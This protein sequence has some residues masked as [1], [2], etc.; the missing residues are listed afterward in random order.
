MKL[1][2]LVSSVAKCRSA[3]RLGLIALGG[4][5]GLVSP[6]ALAELPQG[7]TFD[8]QFGGGNIVNSPAGNFQGVYL[9]GSNALINWDSFNVGA[10]D[11]VHFQSWTAPDSFRVL[12]KINQGTPSMI[13]GT[14]TGN[15]MVGMV[16]PAGVVF[17]GSSV[18]NVGSLLAASASTINTSDFL[19]NS[20]NDFALTCGNG[21]INILPGASLQASN[22][23]MLVGKS[24][25]NRGTL[26]APT[27]L[28]VGGIDTGDEVTVKTL[29]DVISLR[30]K[31]EDLGLESNADA[32]NPDGY[33]SPGAGVTT[34]TNLGGRGVHNS[35]QIK[36][37]KH[38][39][40]ASGDLCGFAIHNTGTINADGGII[41]AVAL[42]G[43]IHNT[44]TIDSTASNG[45]TVRMA[46]PAIVNGTG[47]VV[48]ANAL[49]TP[50]SG[51]GGHVLLATHHNTVL[52][53]GSTVSANA[54]QGDSRGGVVNSIS[55]HS[56]YIEQGSTVM[57]R[58]G[59]SGGTGGTINVE[60]GHL[61]SEGI[62]RASAGTQGDFGQINLVTTQSMNIV[63]DA[64][65]IPW[66]ASNLGT[67]LCSS[68]EISTGNSLAFVDANL[69]L[70]TDGIL[71]FH[72]NLDRNPSNNLR[73][74]RGNL[75]ISGDRV[76]LANAAGV[77]SISAEGDVVAI[78]D[79]EMAP[80][81][82]TGLQLEAGR[83]MNI[84]GDIGKSS[85]LQSVTMAAG[86][87]IAIGDPENLMTNGMI[88][89]DG[90]IRF[91]PDGNSWLENTGVATVSVFADNYEVTSTLGD[92]TFGEMQ[93][94]STAG[95][96]SINAA[97][98]ITVGDVTAAGDLDVTA[99]DI[100]ILL[101]DGVQVWNSQGEFTSPG[102]GIIASGEISFSS[103]P[104]FDLTSGLNAPVFA[105]S[106]GVV[107]NGLLADQ[108]WGAI[109]NFD[110]NMLATDEAG[111][112]LLGL[113]EPG[114]DVPV[115]PVD[116]VDPVNPVI[117]VDPINPE[118]NVPVDPIP[119]DPVNPSPVD[120]TPVDT[121]TPELGDSLAADSQIGLDDQM[122]VSD[123]ESEINIDATPNP[124]SLIDFGVEVKTTEGGQR[125]PLVN[126]F[127][128]DIVGGGSGMIQ[129]SQQRLD[130]NVAAQAALQ[131]EAVITSQPGIGPD[132]VAQRNTAQIA[133]SLNQAYNEYASSNAGSSGEDFASWLNTSGADPQAK[134]YLDG[135]QSSF[136]DLGNAGLNSAEVGRSSL[137]VANKILASSDSALSPQILAQAMAPKQ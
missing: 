45:G 46:A 106:Q 111:P 122:L 50:G 104:N 6:S 52:A 137:F 62:L 70:E 123:I 132:A 99:P 120:P 20:K 34:P 4:V 57:A 67:P 27:L 7:G 94:I 21:A 9:D 116:P 136:T 79:F 29:G 68:S 47:G 103:N 135:M 102:T 93:A 63:G 10:G 130:M 1:N 56:Q 28:M 90:D 107:T 18:V 58:G 82:Y 88:R 11:H 37:S 15:G 33:Y 71:T 16:N 66:D 24:V 92:V 42:S 121:V 38:I 49:A 83:A 75:K 73:R 32:E 31:G 48:S 80:G 108:E 12:N 109:E 41:D 43:L 53:S 101:R 131:Y 69:R 5:I 126:D 72:T 81:V 98:R 86:D 113:L 112:M 84:R 127:A 14:I 115:E 22:H 35:G 85:P 133:S 36:A 61:V 78:G 125:A 54:F 96:L 64:T 3:K 105:S 2:R 44:G 19:T 134:S 87:F 51:D 114:F 60:S 89:A 119:V 118:P 100:Q 77:T 128:A 40:I 91:N 74:V 8:P 117:P 95:N 124:L 76:D 25:T 129:I 55:A 30:L 59:L 26:S 13:R 97:N 23:M 17:F 39:A 110:H 65:D